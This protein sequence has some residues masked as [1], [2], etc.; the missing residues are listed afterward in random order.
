MDYRKKNKT[1]GRKDL[2]KKRDSPPKRFLREILQQR[3]GSSGIPARD[4]VA[5]GESAAVTAKGRKE[6]LVRNLPEV[7]TG[8][9]SSGTGGID[10]PLQ[11]AGSASIPVAGDRG[12]LI[13]SVG[14]FRLA[15]K[16]LSGCPRRKLKKA[17]ARSD[18]AGTGGIQQPRTAGMTGQVETLTET[19]KLPRSGGSTTSETVRHPKRPRVWKGPGDYKEALTGM[20]VAIFKDTIPEKKVT[21]HDQDSILAEMGKV[22]R[23]IPLGELPH[24]KSDTGGRRINI[25]VHLCRPT[26]WSVA[27]QSH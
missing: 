27:H 16:L 8:T 26:V 20:R 1:N 2:K 6:P 9:F 19:P 22:L 23:K 15:K 25:Q 14:E 13:P 24:L 7:E 12:S 3:A 21:I 10:T 5:T 4:P 18:M 11:G 17:K